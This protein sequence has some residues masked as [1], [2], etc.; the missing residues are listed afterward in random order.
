MGLSK[1]SEA[2]HVKY[3][4]KELAKAER[5]IRPT[6]FHSV[7]NF[8]FHNKPFER[9]KVAY[10]QNLEYQS[11]KITRINDAQL[12]PEK[13]FWNADHL[14]WDRSVSF[15]KWRFFQYENKYA[16]YYAD[17][18]SFYL[19]VRKIRWRNMNCLLLVDYRYH[20]SSDFEMVY[21]LALKIAEKTKCIALITL[22]SVENEKIVLKRNLNKTFAEPIPVMTTNPEVLT[23]KNIMTT[24][25]DSDFDTFYGDNVW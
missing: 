7:I 25:A 8:L 2:L 3:G 4:N 10:P 15:L 18:R 24:A 17:D 13:S 21:K 6:G 23:A 5:F 16:F 22:S 1:A 20:K 19:V 12:I 14:E 11:S 9:E